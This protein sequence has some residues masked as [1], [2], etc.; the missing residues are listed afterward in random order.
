MRLRELHLGA[1]E[2][3]YV[4]AVSPLTAVFLMPVRLVLSGAFKVLSDFERLWVGC[5]E[6]QPNTRAVP[7]VLAIKPPPPGMLAIKFP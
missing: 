6:V 4:D 5:E 2:C 3:A 1:R 7:G